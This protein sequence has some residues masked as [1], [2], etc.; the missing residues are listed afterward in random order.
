M[1]LDHSSEDSVQP[2][3]DS[4]T[5]PDGSL[6]IRLKFDPATNSATCV[7]PKEKLSANQIAAIAANQV[8]TLSALPGQAQEITG[9]KEDDVVEIDG[10]LYYGNVRNASSPVADSSSAGDAAETQMANAGKYR[11]ILPNPGGTI[12]IDGVGEAKAGG[13]GERGGI[14]RSL[15]AS[16]NTLFIPASSSPFAISGAAS[17]PTASDSAT[18]ILRSL[19]R[20]CLVCGDDASGVHY[21][22]VTCEACKGFFRRSNQK[23]IVYK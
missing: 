16:P 17:S 9:L 1:K 19:E 14:C 11:S 8:S 10:G 22:V 20:R 23:G 21:G 15:L 12:I 5:L 4:V 2:E 7:I 13:G 18:S 3:G 6:K